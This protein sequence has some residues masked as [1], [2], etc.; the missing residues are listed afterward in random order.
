MVL[1]NARRRG[2]NLVLMQLTPCS[3]VCNCKLLAYFFLFL[4]E[5]KR[6]ILFVSSRLWQR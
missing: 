6:L 4:L 2:V 3:Y 5:V 1:R